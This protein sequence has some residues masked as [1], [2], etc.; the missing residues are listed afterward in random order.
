ML[1]SHPPGT[2][3]S[4]TRFRWRSWSRMGLQAEDLMNERFRRYWIGCPKRTVDA[5]VPG[6]W[7]D[8]V[9]A[10]SLNDGM[11]VAVINTVTCEPAIWQKSPTIRAPSLTQFYFTRSFLLVYWVF[12][13]T[14]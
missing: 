6:G 10:E 14:N 1:L 11:T 5:H 13:L 12:S 7:R 9:H 8:A 4:T 3:A 2:R